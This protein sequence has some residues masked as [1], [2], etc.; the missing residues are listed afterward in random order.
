M[1]SSD[2]SASLPGD[3][4][5]V[6]VRGGQLFAAGGHQVLAWT[7]GKGGKPVPRGTLR[8]EHYALDIQNFT[9]GQVLTTE[10]QS[11]RRLAVAESAPAGGYLVLPSAT[12]APLANV[13]QQ[14]HATVRLANVGSKAITFGPPAFQESADTPPVL[15]PVP[16]PLQPG[17]VRLVPIEVPKTVKGVLHHTLAWPS[18]DPEIGRAHV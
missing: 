6:M 12:Y 10:F 15:L 4:Y 16:P 3:A 2:L 8:S 11:V 17:E 9:E 5:G 18:D 14:L 1:C 7:L 13:G